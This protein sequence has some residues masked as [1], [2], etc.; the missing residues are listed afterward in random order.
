MSE[1][2][3]RWAYRKWK[4]TRVGSEPLG[5]YIILAASFLHYIWA[6]LLL[7]DYRAGGSTPVHI[8]DEVCGGRFRAAFVLAVFATSAILFPF[9]SQVGK[10]T[11]AVM[12][13]PQ[14]TLLLLSAGSGLSS[15]INEQYADGVLRGWA[16]IL[17][18]QLPVII[19]A[20]LYTVAVLEAAWVDNRIVE[21]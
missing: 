18:D 21:L 7:V 3:A 12:L 13:V 20:L 5:K 14:Q 10:R 9:V 1:N 2:L 6:S 4:T 19:F 8:I 15:V 11:F 16:F 17:S